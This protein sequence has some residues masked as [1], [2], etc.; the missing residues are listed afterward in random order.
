MKSILLTIGLLAAST[1]VAA[2]PHEYAGSSGGAFVLCNP[3]GSGPDVGGVC[4][5]PGHIAPG[6]VGLAI[7]DDL[8]TPASGFVCEDVNANAICGDGPD[9]AIAF[10]G[11]TSFLYHGGPLFVQP[12][13]PVF[14]GPVLSVCGT[15][16]FGTHG[17]VFHT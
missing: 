10:C 17:F 16:S 3:T 11:S 5:P 1:L 12:D 4:I 13:D 9:T 15:T 14:G 8:F 6:T 2:T 7:V